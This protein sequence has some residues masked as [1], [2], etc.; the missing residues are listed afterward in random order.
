MECVRGITVGDD[1]FNIRIESCS[2]GY[3]G[4][5]SRK[6]LDQNSS[7][8]KLLVVVALIVWPRYSE[9]GEE[10]DPVVP[11]EKGSMVN[12]LL[13]NGWY[14]LTVTWRGELGDKATVETVEIARG[15]WRIGENDRRS[16]LET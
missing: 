13:L 6:Q 7:E 11:K 8:P 14:D 15:M 3:F 10:E 12:L 1:E 9:E 16:R 4:Y 5:P 2:K